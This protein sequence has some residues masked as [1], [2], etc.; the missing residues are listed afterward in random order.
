MKIIFIDRDG[1][2][3]KD[4]FAYV[5]SWERFTF[6][7]GSLEA[8]KKLTGS[9]YEIVIISNQAGV[10]K[11]D[12]SLEELNVINENMLIEIETVAGKRPNTYYCT[13]TDE[14]NCGCRKPKLGLFRQAEKK[15]GKVNYKNVYYIGDQERDIETA[16]NLGA[17]SIL[18]LSGRTDKEELK[19]WDIKPDHVKENL[20]DAVNLVLGGSR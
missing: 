3:N 11:G 6:L 12:Y 17:K 10:S 13:H 20:M 9:G 16:K 8:L 18:V 1:V 2:I 19:D 4:L 15:L 5:T 7:D 14:D